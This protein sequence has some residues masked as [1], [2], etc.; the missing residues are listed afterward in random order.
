M[1][2]R[3]RRGTEPVNARSAVRARRVLS[4]IALPV[5]LLL[6]VFFLARAQ[7]TGE[8]VWGWE[9]AIAGAV[10]LAAAIDLA[11]LSRRR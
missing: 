8:A 2:L 4:L 10:A 7:A 6:A 1:W 3:D 5:A 9:A 11:V